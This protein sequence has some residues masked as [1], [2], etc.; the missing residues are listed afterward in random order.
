MDQA[1][2]YVKDN[3]GIDTE[4]SYPYQAEDETCQ[5]KRKSVGATVV[6]W[7]D[8]ASGNETALQVATANVGPISVAID[9]TGWEFL[10][11]TDGVYIGDSCTTYS[12]NHGM[13]VVGYDALDGLAYW[14][15]K[16][17]WGEDWGK[18]GYILMA[19][20]HSNNC[21]ISSKAS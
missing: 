7:V 18:Q 1:F 17:S 20:N 13:T 14:T 9:V 12:L 4:A 15:V 10:F 6:S 21:G 3:K 11:Y 5:F 8:I 16:N 2:E 19:R